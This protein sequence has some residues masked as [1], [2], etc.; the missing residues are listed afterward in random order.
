[1][2]QGCTSLTTAP[3]LPATTLDGRC[4]ESMFQGCTS[5]TTAPALPATTLTDSCYRNMFS[6]CTSIK[7]S[8]TQTGDYQTVYRIPKSGTG[9]TTTEA[10]SEM[11]SG[12]G[13]TFKGTPS[14]N[15]TYYLSTSNTVV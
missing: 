3:A 13:G 4:Y 2:F 8:T 5:L 15:T 7:L 1:M 14:I 11:F 12:T 10:L 6:G 9:T